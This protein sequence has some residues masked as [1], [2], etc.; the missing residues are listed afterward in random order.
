MITPGFI[1]VSLISHRPTTVFFQFQSKFHVL[2]RSSAKK[3]GSEKTSVE[4]VGGRKNL[5]QEFD[6]LD[7][8]PIISKAKH[9]YVTVSFV[10]RSENIMI[11]DFMIYPN[12]ISRVLGLP[13]GKLN[14]HYRGSSE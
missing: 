12:L 9:D 10:S 13:I 2:T 1:N 6:N 3:N 5:S 11:Y 7:L 14:H 8:D 4:N